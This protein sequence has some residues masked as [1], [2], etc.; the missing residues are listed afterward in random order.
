M[1]LYGTTIFLSAFLLFLV[2]AIAIG[3]L[4]HRTVFGRRCYAAG[5]NATAAW[6]EIA[7]NTPALFQIYMAYFGLGQLGIHI[8]SFAALLAGITFTTTT[9]RTSIAGRS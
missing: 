1:L 7:R 9:T 6:V 5:S 8:G 3:L 4:M 2:L